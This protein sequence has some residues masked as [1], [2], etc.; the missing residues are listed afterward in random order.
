[1]EAAALG[2]RHSQEGFTHCNTTATSGF[3]SHD[4]DL[5]QDFSLIKWI[6]HFNCHSNI[7]FSGR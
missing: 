4:D 2:G 7:S 3:Y 6:E 1:M 5:S